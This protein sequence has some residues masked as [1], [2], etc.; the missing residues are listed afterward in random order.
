MLDVRSGWDFS[1]PED[2]AA[3]WCYVQNERPS[4]VIGSGE[5]ASSQGLAKASRKSS[6]YK[7][8]LKDAVAHVKVLAEVYEHQ[9]SHGGT[10]VHEQDWKSKL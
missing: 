6:R 7:G 10:F 2:V 9:N 8:V 4:M 3:L 5:S 1:K